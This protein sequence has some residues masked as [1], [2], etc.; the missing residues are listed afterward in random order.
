MTTVRILGCAVALA[1]VEGSMPM[2]AD[3]TWVELQGLPE[4]RQE[5]PSILL[6]G[7]IYAAGGMMNFALTAVNRFES[8]DIRS[9]HWQRLA[10]LPLGVHH[11]AMATVGGKIYV[12]GGASGTSTPSDR[13]FAYAPEN[14]TWSERAHLPRATWAAAAVTFQERIY[15]FGG[16]SASNFSSNPNLAHVQV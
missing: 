11:T 4:A 15:L 8:Y 13:V 3:G 1:L 5:C 14:D 2:F 12:L 7:K 9:N 16:T 10:D 6:G